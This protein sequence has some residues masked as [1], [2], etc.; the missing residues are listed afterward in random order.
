RGAALRLHVEAQCVSCMHNRTHRVGL[1]VRMRKNS[2]RVLMCAAALAA[3]AVVSAPTSRNAQASLAR[4]PPLPATAEAAY[5]QWVDNGG[6]LNPGP[7]FESLRDDIKAQVLSLSRP[8][9][10]AGPEGGVS[11]KDQALAEK[12][13]A[14]TDTARVEQ[15]IRSVRTTQAALVQKWQAD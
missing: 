15:N 12:I 1:C 8:A 7:A 9:P 3:G 4:V 6:V 2:A 5:G 10:A 14:F 13:T 11:R